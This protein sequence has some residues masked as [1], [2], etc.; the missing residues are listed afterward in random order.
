MNETWE[1]NDARDGESSRNDVLKSS[2]SYDRKIP[3]EGKGTPRTQGA[4]GSN[5]TIKG[6]RTCT[7]VPKQEP[8]M[9]YAG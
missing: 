2:G 8:R 9:L 7:E 1:G 3:N 6:E 5:S 4:M